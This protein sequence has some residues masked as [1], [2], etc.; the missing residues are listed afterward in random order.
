MSDQTPVGHCQRNETDVYIGRGPGLT[1]F[2]DCKIGKRGW[3]GNPYPLEEF[4]RED[5]IRLFAADFYHVLWVKQDRD[6][7]VAVAALQGK[8]LGCWCRD[9]ETPAH[10]TP[11]HGDVIAAAADLLSIVRQESQESLF[12]FEDSK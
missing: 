10:Q 1:H 11:C 7:Q 2:G 9:L 12:A 8:S 4:D 5:S 6:Y 3:L